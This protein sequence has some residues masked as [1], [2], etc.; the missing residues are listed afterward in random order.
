MRDASHANSTR[1]HALF[2]RVVVGRFGARDVSLVHGPWSEKHSCARME[3]LDVIRSEGS[4]V[5]PTFP[6]HPLACTG[7]TR[8]LSELLALAP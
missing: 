5:V 8:N 4:S 3:K 1:A 6:K 2:T 7:S